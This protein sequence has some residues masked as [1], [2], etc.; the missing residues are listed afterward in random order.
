MKLNINYSI[1]KKPETI[2]IVNDIK[3]LQLLTRGDIATSILYSSICN[4]LTVCTF[5]K[6]A[7]VDRQGEFFIVMDEKFANEHPD[8]FEHFDNYELWGTPETLWTVAP[9]TVV[10]ES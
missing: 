3:D 1:G 8:P 5:E 7:R 4:C 2:I 6:P 10:L 9:K